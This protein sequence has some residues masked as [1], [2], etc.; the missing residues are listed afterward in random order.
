M[1]AK[2]ISQPYI[3]RQSDASTG[4]AS[5]HE[6]DHST[7][8]RSKIRPNTA[9]LMQFRSSQTKGNISNI[10]KESS[11]SFSDRHMNAELS[12]ADIYNLNK[13]FNDKINI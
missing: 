4:F 13:R 7:P 11:L 1:T 12:A 8:V 5:A 9:N 10:K 6:F 3:N 2:K